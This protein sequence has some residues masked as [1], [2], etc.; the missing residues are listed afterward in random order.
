MSVPVRLSAMYVALQYI[1]FSSHLVL[2]EARVSPSIWDTLPVVTVQSG[3]LGKSEGIM[4]VGVVA[5]GV[6]RGLEREGG[7]G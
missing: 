1:S 7:R 2:A 3:A 4:A 5:A 6:E